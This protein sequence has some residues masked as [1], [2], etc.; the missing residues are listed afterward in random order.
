MSTKTKDLSSRIQTLQ[1]RLEEENETR[2]RIDIPPFSSPQMGSVRRPSNRK[3]F[4]FVKFNIRRVPLNIL[5]NIFIIMDF[6]MQIKIS[7][8]F[9]Q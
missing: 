6:Y 1:E 2:N 7:Y 8:L 3:L 5:Y 4:L 9:A